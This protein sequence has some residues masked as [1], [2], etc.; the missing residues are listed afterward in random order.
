MEGH[1]QSLVDC[2]ITRLTDAGH[3]QFAEYTASG[4]VSHLNAAVEHFQ[5]VLDQCPASHPD[6]AAALTNLASARLLGYIRNHLPD[7]DTTI[8]LF[9]DALALRPQHHLDRPFSLYIL[10]RALNWRHSKKC[11]AA[12]IHEAAQLYHELLPLCPE[13]TYLRSI[14]S[15]TGADYVIGDLVNV[16][17][18]S[19]YIISSCLPSHHS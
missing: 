14:A 15:G 7:I 8:S 4:T 5:F 2:E 17:F 16:S 10:S 19:P 13:G 9:R 11:T 18:V 12:D 1:L 3:A 6:H